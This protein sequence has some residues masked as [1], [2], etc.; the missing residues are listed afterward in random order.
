M[1][2][3]NC[4]PREKLKEYLAGWADENQTQQIEAHLSQ[5]AMC[6]E[7]IVALEREPDTLVGI[8]SSLKQG[9]PENES[10]ELAALL[11]KAGDL[12]QADVHAVDRADHARSDDS[13]SRVS[14]P[15]K[16]GPYVLQ[17]PL[18]RGGMGSVF[19]AR[20][21]Q[22]GKS[23][24]IKLLPWRSTHREHFE[25]RFQREVRAAGGLDHPSIVSATDAGQ[26]NGTHYLVM[27][28]IDGLDLSRLVRAMGQ[29]RLADACE[30]I[31]QVA[32]GLSHAHAERIVHRDIKPSNLM[33]NRRGQVKI[34]DFGL[35]RL[36]PWNEES[37]ELTT[38]GQLMGTL[39]YMAPEQAERAESVDYR[40]DLYSLGATLFRLLCGRAPLA[41]S[42][43]QSPLAKLRLLATEEPPKLSTLRPDAPQELTKLVA[44][45]LA[46]DPSDR[47]ASAAHVA[48]RLEQFCHSHDLSSLLRTAVEKVELLQPTT[49]SSSKAV[50]DVDNQITA[51]PS[52]SS[53]LHAAEA[54]A[55]S[56]RSSV[57]HWGW[58]GTACAAMAGLIYCGI[59]IWID[60]QSGWLHIDSDAKVS[61][62][63][64][65]DSAPVKQWKI[66]PGA[67]TT[68]L[69]AGKYR[70]V[71]KEGSDG[72]QLDQQQLLV[73]K[74]GVT[75]AK[76][77]KDE[78]S[79]E[80]SNIP[81]VDSTLSRQSIK[82][83]PQAA[84]P[85]AST[86]VLIPGDA[87]MISSLADEKINY[88]FVI[89]ADSTA[90]LPMVG[91]VN[92]AGLTVDAFEKELNKRYS[93]W[94]THPAIEVF[95]DPSQPTVA[96]SESIPIRSN[97]KEGSSSD[98]AIKDTSDIAE[99]TY[100]GRP[101]SDWLK[102]ISLERSHDGLT[103]A[104]QAISASIS[105]RTCS[106]ISSQLKRDLPNVRWEE[107]FS[108]SLNRKNSP[109]WLYRAAFAVL[110]KASPDEF[111]TST[112][113]DYFD[114]VLS[115][116]Q[117]TYDEHWRG[118]VIKY[119]IPYGVTSKQ[120]EPLKGWLNAQLAQGPSSKHFDGT[121]EC[122]LRHVFHPRSHDE[123]RE[124]WLKM[125]MASPHIADLFWLSLPY[126]DSPGFVETE[127]SIPITSK[128]A[129]YYIGGN[130]PRSEV[131]WRPLIRLAIKTLEEASGEPNDKTSLSIA[132]SAAILFESNIQPT[133]HLIPELKEIWKLWSKRLVES[134]SL[135]S[136]LVEISYPMANKFEARSFS[137]SSP[138]RS[139]L[140]SIQ[141]ALVSSLAKFSE[142]SEAL[143]EVLLPGAAR[144]FYARNRD[145]IDPWNYGTHRFANDLTALAK[146]AVIELKEQS[147]VSGDNPQ[148]VASDR[149]AEDLRDLCSLRCFNISKEE[150]AVRL[151]E[152]IKPIYAAKQFNLL[153]RDKDGKVTIAESADE[154]ARAFAIEAT[155][156]D[157]D[158]DQLISIDEYIA[159]R[160]EWHC[161]F[162]RIK[163]KP[164]EAYIEFAKKQVKK[165]DK[166]N[167][168]KLSTE[169]Q[170]KMIVSPNA[171]DTDNDGYVDALEYAAYRAR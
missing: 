23:V 97:E 124:E 101:L 27:E 21:Q 146:G 72:V 67:N 159:Y 46:R 134:E 170:S 103:E 114:Y 165:Y 87:L 29:V 49:A 70:I 81:P 148:K 39:D 119:A 89:Q 149:E 94:L 147:T 137:Q 127:T 10:S 79:S 57:I 163:G 126:S 62:E 118:I 59:T 40:A 22:L 128:V 37:A 45:M 77:Y 140:V 32:L 122:L 12:V 51:R 139:Y 166:D 33:L 43:D 162:F 104:L 108:E 1:S 117:S 60:S 151:L 100:K 15:A 93:E 9:S 8:V 20:H 161:S 95:R 132:Y 14:A 99:P 68:K 106:R 13:A 164:T 120:L 42:P 92:V 105:D 5:C 115:E 73:T 153:D 90:K 85:P 112:E 58:I 35:A 86:A 144:S 52:S 167:D 102:M 30:L 78:K 168:G 98:S 25:A 65:S 156:L 141:H 71:L 41:A 17:R 136:R 91:T 84:I 74:G 80:S 16:V 6:E 24:A 64:A 152:H 26:E 145:Q 18:G 66:E 130:Y 47:P 143:I 4:W 129:N 160:D 54:N 56:S 36:G 61:I 135:R 50:G 110:Q 19:L 111:D 38:V 155:V 123:N 55:K 150:M 34:L 133:D 2:E 131:C 11:A 3:N 28:F 154:L 96:T 88:K 76:V 75:I 125:L 69:Y 82:N 157:N 109:L 113:V 138:K 116:L 158:H 83:S 142:P 7:T 53:A 44:E 121:V 169:E 31:R 171:A 48:E 107:I 63:I